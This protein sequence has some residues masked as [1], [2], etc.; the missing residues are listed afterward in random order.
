MALASLGG[1][2][3]FIA[4]YFGNGF[5]AKSLNEGLNT[6]QYEF[7]EG[8]NY[9]GQSPA[10]Q[11]EFLRQELAPLL[12]RPYR[13]VLFLDFHTGL[14]EDGVLAIIR[15]INPSVPL[16]AEAKTLLGARERDGIEF[17]SGQDPGF[18][19]TAGDVIDFVPLLAPDPG[20]VLAVTME[21]GTM[22]TGGLPQLRSAMRIILQNQ[23]HFHG[24][25]KPP[26][27]A[28]VE[29]NFRE[30]F[31]QSD[32]AWRLQ[33]M[34]EAAVHDNATR[35]AGEDRRQDCPSR[36]FDHVPDGRGHGVATCSRPFWA[37][38]RR[39]GPVAGR[40][41]LRVGHTQPTREASRRRVG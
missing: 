11:T 18:F 24:C 9:G 27:C 26:V 3:Q 20:K 30:L 1:E 10:Q 19:P 41:T 23:A 16:L 15:G 39:S 28:G 5:D 36:P 6:G 4:S 35:A 31:T 29:R 32:T 8:V 7:P 13:K 37:P 22:G 21:Y 33:V 17:R 2:A 12:A 40:E 25:S 14:G 38:S 34:Q